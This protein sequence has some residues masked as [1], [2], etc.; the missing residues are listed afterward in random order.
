MA[1]QHS[2][3]VAA[4]IAALLVVPAVY[5]VLRAYDILFRPPEQNPATIVWSAHIAMFWRLG[6]GLYAAGLI[7]P[8]AFMAARRDLPRTM[9][10][11]G[12]LTVIVAVM[13]SV[14]GALLP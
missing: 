14:Q 13:I 12:T 3:A 2:S 11:L 5:A 6:I 7:A 1:K 10:V 8:F 9:R 4:A